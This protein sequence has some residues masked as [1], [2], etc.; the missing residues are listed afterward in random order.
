MTI[1]PT[2]HGT[3]MATNCRI[4]GRGVDASANIQAFCNPADDSALQPD[5][6]QSPTTT[7]PKG[8]GKAAIL[9]DAGELQQLVAWDSDSSCQITLA[10]PKTIDAIALGRRIL[11]GLPAKQGGSR[12]EG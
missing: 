12:G 6:P 7:A 5:T 4:E 10:V 8:I 3:D 1:T 11:D 2:S 9:V